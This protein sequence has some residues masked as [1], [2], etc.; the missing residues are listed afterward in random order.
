M[1]MVVLRRKRTNWAIQQNP[2]T[3]TINRTEKIETGGGFEELHCEVG[4]F[5][6]RIYQQASQAPREV[7]TLAGTKQVDGTW[8]MLADWK[9]DIRAGPNVLD[10]FTAP[11]LGCFR[12]VEVY[13]QIVNGELVGHQVTL[14][15]VS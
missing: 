1:D 13:Q 3:I 12:V 6:V 11:G 10:E 2:T 7:S 5:A 9:A 15:R 14:E 4:P 8:G